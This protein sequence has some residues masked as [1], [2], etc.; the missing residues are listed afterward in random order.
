MVPESCFSL[1]EKKLNKKLQTEH[2]NQ[3]FQ[4]ERAIFNILNRNLEKVDYI[5]DI[6]KCGEDAVKSN[7]V[8]NTFIEHKSQLSVIKS[9]I[10]FIVDFLFV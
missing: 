4:L 3:I 7:T 5:A 10:R 2:C 6:L 1:E 9:A 8:V